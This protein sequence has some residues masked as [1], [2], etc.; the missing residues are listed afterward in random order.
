[1]LEHIHVHVAALCS[2]ADEHS[3][4]SRRRPYTVLVEHVLRGFFGFECRTPEERSTLKLVGVEVMIMRHK[5]Q[6][7]GAEVIG[8]SQDLPFDSGPRAG[9]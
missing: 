3:E 1:M 7:C 9:L 2:I 6:F 8:A 5:P 4:H